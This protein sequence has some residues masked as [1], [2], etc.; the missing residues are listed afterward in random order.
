MNMDNSVHTHNAN[1][2]KKCFI[3]AMLEEGIITEDTYIEMEQYA[4]LCSTPK[5]LGSYINSLHESKNPQFFVV[6]MVDI[7]KQTEEN[8]TFLASQKELNERI[9]ALEEENLRLKGEIIRI[10]HIEPEV[11]TFYSGGTTESLSG[12]KNEA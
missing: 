8:D 3:D 11:Q 4:I 12:V 9:K 7:P 2:V 10:S 5:V 6:K 1:I